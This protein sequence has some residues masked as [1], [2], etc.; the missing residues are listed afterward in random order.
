MAAT[1]AFWMRHAGQGA[2][3]RNRMHARRTL[4]GYLVRFF[5]EDS[6]YSY[7]P[8]RIVSRV[9]EK[10]RENPPHNAITALN[11]DAVLVRMH[12]LLIK[13]EQPD[14]MHQLALQEPKDVYRSKCTIDPLIDVLYRVGQLSIH[15][16]YQ[17]Y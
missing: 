6:T 3:A 14:S 16:R 4:D 11:D 8:F 9:C 15:V 2:W 17:E 7:P 5:L 10:P 13:N 12:E 1:W